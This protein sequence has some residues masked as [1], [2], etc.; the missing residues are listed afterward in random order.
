MRI[1]LQEIVT[2]FAILFVG[3]DIEVSVVSDD[4]LDDRNAFLV[5]IIY[6]DLDRL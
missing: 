3:E 6:L 1:D 5:I 4:I 2:K